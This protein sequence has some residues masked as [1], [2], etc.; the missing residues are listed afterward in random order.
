MWR[1]VLDLT[2][3]HSTYFLICQQFF[4]CIRIPKRAISRLQLLQRSAQRHLRAGLLK[5]TQVITEQGPKIAVGKI[6]AK[7]KYGHEWFIPVSIRGQYHRK[8]NTTTG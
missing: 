6:D 4:L 3:P 2:T 5:E 7:I 1:H 8:V